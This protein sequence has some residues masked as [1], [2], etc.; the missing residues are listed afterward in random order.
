[1]PKVSKL[2]DIATKTTSPSFAVLPLLLTLNALRRTFSTFIYYFYF[3]FEHVFAC[4]SINKLNIKRFIQPN[5]IDLK[6]EMIA[7]FVS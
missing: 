7:I 5:F 6:R 4:W 2:N 3:Y 1:M